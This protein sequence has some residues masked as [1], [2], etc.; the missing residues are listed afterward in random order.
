MNSSEIERNTDSTL[1]CFDS[2]YPIQQFFSNVVL[3]TELQ[4]LLKVK[5]DLS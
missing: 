5:E 3:G 4:C 2:L 1:I